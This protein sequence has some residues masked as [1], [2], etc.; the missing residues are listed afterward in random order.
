MDDYSYNSYYERD[1]CFI[2]LLPPDNNENNILNLDNFNYN[3]F[4]YCEEKKNSLLLIGNEEQF[5]LENK[6]NRSDESNL[7][8]LNFINN[9][10]IESDVNKKNE[11]KVKMKKIILMKK[12]KKRKYK[13]QR[14]YKNC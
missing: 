13:N 8:G 1:R 11:I 10:N 2:F 6:R 9:K 5:L 3:Q 4:D 14:N 7:E 12:M